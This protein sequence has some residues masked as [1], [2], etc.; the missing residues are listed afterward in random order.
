[1]TTNT[2]LRFTIKAFLATCIFVVFATA[3]EKPK[4]PENDRIRIAE[5]FHIGE[6]LGNEVWSGWDKAPFAVLLVTPEFEFLIR[7]P[8]PSK[9]FT[10]LGYDEMLKSDVLFRKR[11]FSPNLLATFPAV[12][13]IST[14]VIGQA[15][16]TNVKTPT[17]W[18]R[19]ML[20]EHFHQLQYS[21][22][23]YNAEVDSLHLSRGDQTGMWML[24]YPFPYD[25]PEVNH[26]FTFMCQQLYEA[27][28]A[29]GTSSFELKVFKYRLARREFQKLLSNDD[30]KYFSFQAWQEGVARYTEYKIA[31]LAGEKYTPSEKFRSL[32]DFTHFT[33]TADTTFARTYHALP[34]LSLAKLKRE[35]VY[36][37]GAAEAF[38][39]DEVNPQWRSLYFKEKF[40]LEKYWGK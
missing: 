26:I 17:A 37:F 8:A 4:L 30:Y 24:N 33:N 21:Q 1:M 9:D 11:V 40:Y 23:M 25:S 3:Q 19:T 12:G 27:L 6:E 34:T 18:V 29:R 28:K 36:P 15:E 13:G 32:P 35:V 39:L 7:H 22:P 10:S 38:L 16:N 14:I 31:K 2:L 20:H 5:A